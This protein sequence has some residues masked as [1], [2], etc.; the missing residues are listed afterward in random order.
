MAVNEAAIANELLKIRNSPMNPFRPGKPSDENMATLIQ[1]QSS[2]VRCIRPPKSSMAA[3]TAP[4]F[5]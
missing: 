1:P 2:G 3:Q 5:E 4:L